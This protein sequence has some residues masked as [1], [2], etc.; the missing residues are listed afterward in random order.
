VIALLPDVVLTVLENLAEQRLFFKL[1]QKYIIQKR[2]ANNIIA[3]FN[4]IKHRT[5][6]HNYVNENI[7]LQNVTHMQPSADILNE[8]KLDRVV[9][10]PNEKDEEDEEV[11]VFM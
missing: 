6:S 1:E 2:I 3:I 11:S 7:D 8:I 4:F 5:I 9:E 10:M